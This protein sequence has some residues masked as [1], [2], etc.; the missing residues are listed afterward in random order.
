[1]ANRWMPWIALFAFMAGGCATLTLEPVDYSWGIESVLAVAPDGAVAGAPKTLSFN[2]GPLFDL[3][4]GGVPRKGK[5]TIRVIRN[6]QGH[7]FVTALLFKHVYVFSPGA[8][9]LK[10]SRKILVDA[11]GMKRPVFNQRDP[12][13]QLVNGKQVLMLNEKG[14]SGEK[15]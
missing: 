5:P 13:I 10:L 15:R 8:E 14:I 11:D 6:R 12:F 3:E 2:A 1:M 7:Y 9:R 4:L